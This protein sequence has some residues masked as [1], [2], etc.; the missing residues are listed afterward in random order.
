MRS[1]CIR[2]ATC[3]VLLLPAISWAQNQL[4]ANLLGL[5]SLELGPNSGGGAADDLLFARSHAGHTAASVKPALQSA[6]AVPAASTAAAIP[7]VQPQR[8]VQAGASR[9]GF[10]G[11]GHV[12]QRYAGTGSYANTQFSLEPPD[13]GLCAGNGYVMEPINNAIAVFDTTGKRVGGPMALSQFFKLMP[14]VVR[15]APPV[16]GQFISDPR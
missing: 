11:L 4:P 3:V 1:F 5:T 13:Q 15:S 8:V 16:F 9:T 14:E 12:D 10:P 2:T 7:V 6:A